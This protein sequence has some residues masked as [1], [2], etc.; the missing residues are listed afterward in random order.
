MGSYDLD[1]PEETLAQLGDYYSLLTRW[2]ER[3]HLVA[4]CAPEEFATRH[5]LES[6]L[7][8]TYLPPHCA[9]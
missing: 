7:L 5:V 2:N 1:L 8:L 3:L 9:W 6:L 4:P